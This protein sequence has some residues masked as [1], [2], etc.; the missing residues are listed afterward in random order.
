MR[1]VPFDRL[2]IQPQ[3]HRDWF[4]RAGGLCFELDIAT[5]SAFAALWRDYENE[6]RPAPVAFLNRHPIAENDALFALFAA[7]Q[8]LLSE[9][10]ELVVTPGEN[11]LILDSA[12]G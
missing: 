8:I 6:Q 1:Q 11:S 4:R 7:V 9:A 10:P 3:V 5:A 12:T 2:L